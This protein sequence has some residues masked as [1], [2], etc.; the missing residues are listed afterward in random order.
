LIGRAQYRHL[1]LQRIRQGT[2]ALSS[3]TGMV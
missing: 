3:K 1:V 2:V